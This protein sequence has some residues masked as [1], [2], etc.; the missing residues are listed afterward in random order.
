M[1]SVSVR[2]CNSAD[3]ISFVNNACSLTYDNYFLLGT[4][5]P[6][7][8]THLMIH[9]YI[10]DCGTSKYTTSVD[11]F[12]PKKSAVKLVTHVEPHVSAVSLLKTAE[13]STI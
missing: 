1:T 10:S 9:I 2:H 11:I 12:Y 7:F 4:L 5:A 13:N 3:A 6:W 8:H